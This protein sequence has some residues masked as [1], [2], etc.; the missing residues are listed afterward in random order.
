MI[1]EQKDYDPYGEWANCDYW[2]WPTWKVWL[3]T[4]LSWSVIILFFI[5]GGYLLVEAL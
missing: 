1:D 2:L 4:G 5:I 3:A